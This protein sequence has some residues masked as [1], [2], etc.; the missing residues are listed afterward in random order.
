M[1]IILRIAG[2][3]AFIH[4]AAEQLQLVSAMPLLS[5]FLSLVTHVRHASVTSRRAPRAHADLPI[6]DV[7]GRRA[8]IVSPPRAAHR[9]V[10]WRQCRELFGHIFAKPR[11]FML[12]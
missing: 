3:R 10:L 2:D 11:V 5:A 7:L 9:R 4:A 1:S 8:S 12:A 6:A